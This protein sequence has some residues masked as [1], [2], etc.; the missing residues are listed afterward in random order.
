MAE[1]DNQDGQQKPDASDTIEEQAPLVTE[2]NLVAKV[3]KA[4]SPPPKISDKDRKRAQAAKD[5]LTSE[6][7]TT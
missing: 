4:P 1:L 7:K 2:E 5:D 6:E 3:E